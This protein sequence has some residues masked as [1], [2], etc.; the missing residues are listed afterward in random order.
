MR[1]CIAGLLANL[2]VRDFQEIEGMQLITQAILAAVNV[3]LSIV[4]DIDRGAKSSDLL[5]SQL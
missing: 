3:S 5:V 2:S 4:I 1:D